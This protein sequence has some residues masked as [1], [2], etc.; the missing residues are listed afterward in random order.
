[1]C[2]LWDGSLSRRA[3]W[4]LRAAA[5]RLR[6]PCTP[7]R[8][9]GSCHLGGH[10][11]RRAPHGSDMLLLSELQVATTPKHLLTVVIDDLGF[12]DLGFRNG[13]QI[14]TPNFNHLHQQGIDMKA[15]YVQPSCSPTRATILRVEFAAEGD[16]VCICWF[17]I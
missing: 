14:D 17:E 3:V 1:M 15:Y 5:P 11:A 6:R 2:I 9:W 12:D 10:T 8:S 16:K 7:P 13:G 4:G